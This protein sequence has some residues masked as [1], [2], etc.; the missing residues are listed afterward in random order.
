MKPLAYRI[1]NAT[2]SDLPLL[3]LGTPLGTTSTVWASV[4]YRLI[5]HF[6]IVITELP[7]HGLDSPN[8]PHDGETTGL[9]VNQIAERTVAVA[10]SLGVDTFYY[11]GCSISG[12]VAQILALDHA[13]RVERVAAVCTAPKFGDADSWNDRIT[14]VREDGTRSLVPDTADRWF[15]A[16]FLDDDI[17]AGH[18]V[19]E[20]LAATSDLAYIACCQ[21][22]TTYDI[23]DRIADIHVPILYM[24]GA[25]DY[26]NDPESMRALSEQVE[27]GTCVVIPDAA[28]IVMVEHP[29]LVADHL[30][31]FFTSA[32]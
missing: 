15:A 27:N 23:T 12:G 13:D 24:A 16:G 11:A 25:Q 5:E 30:E 2:D 3:I 14:T 1:L 7:G 9:T 32:D 31:S 19:L 29:E 8:A 22:L 6:R 21:A 17:A 18:M 20:D 10:D 4:G 26:G 28:H